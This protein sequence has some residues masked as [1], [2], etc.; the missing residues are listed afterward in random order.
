MWKI[1]QKNQ[2]AWVSVELDLAEQ[3][4]SIEAV[5]VDLINLAE[6]RA[7]FCAKMASIKLLGFE[8]TS[9]LPMVV[10][11]TASAAWA[12]AA[13]SEDCE[14]DDLWSSSVKMCIKAC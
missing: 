1:P 8:A 10:G 4:E 14:I 2:H 12:W 7:I 11:S 13:R 3:A 5:E 9:V 6:A